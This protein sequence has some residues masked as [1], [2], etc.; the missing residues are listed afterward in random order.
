MLLAQRQV[1]QDWQDFQAQHLQPISPT[2]QA[3]IRQLALDLPALWFAPT[4]T[5]EERKRLLRCIIREVSLD[6]QPACIRLSI[7]WHSG[8]NTAV[9][10]PRPGHGTPPATAIANRLRQLASHLPDDQIADLLNA[11]SYPTATGLPWTLLRVRAVRRK[12]K[13]PTQCH[14]QAISDQ[15]RGDG[16]IPVKVAADRLGVDRCMIADWFHAGLIPGHQRCPGSAIWVRLDD[17][18]LP[19]LDGSAVL[20]PDMLP[21]DTAQ[22]NLGLNPDQFRAN[23]QTQKLLPFRIRHGEQFRWFVL[24]Y[25][26]TACDR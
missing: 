25:N 21:L 20:L 16:L 26:P 6:T 2:D 5:Q 22:Q 19:R 23:L 18:I 1:E 15:P 12:H 24:P 17:A 7:S 14:Y 8:V 11:E 3:A 9:E 13:I 4:T 10:I